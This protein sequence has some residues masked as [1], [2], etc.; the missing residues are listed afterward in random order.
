MRWVFIG[1]VALNI[2]YFGW[3]LVGNEPS[4][5]APSASSASGPSFPTS[6]QLLAER[7]GGTPRQAPPM[8]SSSAIPAGCPAIGPLVS[9]A[10]AASLVGALKSGKVAAKVVSLQS[11]ATPVY[12]VF[13]PPYPTKSLAL[14]QLRELHARGVDSFVVS[15][16]ADANAISLGTFSNRDSARGVQSRMRAAGY[17]VEI[18]EQTRD[19]A[20]TWVVLT[21]AGAQGFSELIPKGLAPGLRVQRVS[22]PR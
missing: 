9:D 5:L 14:R 10:D 13:I 11:V 20:Q 22:C 6:L 3:H 17:P 16:S 7:P 21:D 4:P 2:L 19:V 1:V 12:W 8:A 18:R 15:D